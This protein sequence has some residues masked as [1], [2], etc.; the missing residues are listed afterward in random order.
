M[1]DRPAALTVEDAG[2]A[3]QRWLSAI[4]NS[5]DTQAARAAARPAEAEAPREATAPPACRKR[6]VRVGR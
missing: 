5:A 1:G 2:A 3:W 4:L 6:Q